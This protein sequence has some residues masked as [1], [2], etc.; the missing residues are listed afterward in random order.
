VA[1]LVDLHDDAVDLVV[2]VVAV[3]EQLLTA[4]VHGVER[5]DDDDLVVDRQACL[6]QPSEGVVVGRVPRRALDGA[7]LVGPQAQLAPRGD[8]RVLLP[9]RAGGGVAGVHELARPGLQLSLVQPLE[10]TE[11]H[12]HLAP[13]LEQ[14]GRLLQRQPFGDGVD[15]GDVGGDVLPHAS[16]AAGG[17]LHEAAVGVGEAH[18]EA[19]DLRLAHE[20]DAV[21]AQPALDA[22]APRQQLVDVEGVVEAQQGDAVGDRREQRRRGG[23]DELGGRVRD[24]QLGELGLE[25]PQL[26]RHG[27]VVGVADRR[28]VELVVEPVVVG[29]LGS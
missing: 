13:H 17:G 2:E 25:L 9:H 21:G 20:G 10:G 24:D 5:V 27:V 12:V 29:D 8:R 3:A 1:Q 14:G 22:G 7:E 15:R 26:S 16:I 19:V 28:F 23:A 11:G 6:P 4:G 18:G